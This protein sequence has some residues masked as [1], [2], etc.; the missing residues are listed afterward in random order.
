VLVGEDPYFFRP[1]AAARDA[2]FN[3]HRYV[4]L[5]MPPIN[6][7]PERPCEIQLANNVVNVIE[8]TVD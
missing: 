3:D 6:D 8:D 2:R 1:E 7:Y 5:V 4:F